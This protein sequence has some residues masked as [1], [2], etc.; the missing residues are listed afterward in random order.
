MRQTQVATL[1]NTGMMEQ[2]SRAPR[3]IPSLDGLRAVSI[4]L[5]IVAHS[6]A[7]LFA[8]GVSNQGIWIVLTN[9]HLGVFTFFVIS[10]YLITYLLRQ[11]KEKTGAIKLF[12]FYQRRTLRIFPAFYVY[13][14][15]IGILTA[16]RIVSV[17]PLDFLMAGTYVFNCEPLTHVL[18]PIAQTDILNRHGWYVGHSWSLCLEEQFYLIWPSLLAFVGLRRSTWIAVSIIFAEPVLRVLVHVLLP[19][20][21]GIIGPILPLSMDPLMFGALAA[22]WQDHYRFE[23]IVAPLLRGWVAVTAAIFV[24]YLSPLL[25][26]RFGGLWTLAFSPTLD[27]V[28]VVILLLW[29]IRHPR[30]VAGKVFNLPLVA[31]IGVLSYS[32]YLWQ[33]PFLVP[34]AINRW[35]V[36]QF[37]LNI[38]CALGAA[39]ASYYLIEKPFLY[40]KREFAQPLDTSIKSHNNVSAPHHIT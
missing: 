40:W 4:T 20:L 11:E 23:R 14:G 10:G 36:Q 32:L 15:I 39:T 6:V 3:H 17:R 19:S 25:G 31:G 13:L 8:N 1:P 21:R 7:H 5:V 12:A 28:A 29:L 18:H 22:L 33:Q 27:S 30:S 34:W 35:P 38:L 16:C 9:G 2:P 37:P 26:A 24:L